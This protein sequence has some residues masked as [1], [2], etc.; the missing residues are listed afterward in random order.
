MINPLLPNVSFLTP[1]RPQKTFDFLT[2]SEGIEMEHWSKTIHN[3][4]ILNDIESYSRY[5]KKLFNKRNLPLKRFKR[6]PLNLFYEN[7]FL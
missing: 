4:M 6:Q 3:F 7:S 2:F 5:T 1:C